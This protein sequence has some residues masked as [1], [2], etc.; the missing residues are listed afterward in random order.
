MKELGQ[1]EIIG[2]FIIAVAMI[3]EATYLTNF[4]QQSEPIVRVVRETEII[5]G[6]NSLEFAKQYLLK[7][8]LYSYYQASYDIASR[9]GYFNLE[10]NSYN[11]IPYL[12]IYSSDYTPDVQSSMKDSIS[13]IFVKYITSPDFNNVRVPTVF[14]V[15]LSNHGVLVINSDETVQVGTE[16]FYTAEELFSFS[17]PV[18]GKIFEL[19]NVADNVKNSIL[20]LQKISPTFT[21]FNNSLSLLQEAQNSNY[22]SQKLQIIITSENIAPDDTNYAARILVSIVDNSQ[23]IPSYDFSSNA[24]SERNIVFQFYLLEGPAT[25]PV[26]TNSCANIIY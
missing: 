20:D 6:I 11:C 7:S 19:Y 15:D 25:V 4:I 26:P 10:T 3:T 8:V 12:N 9:G 21:S 23:K 17:Q 22:E 1:V 24:F 13:S 2:L 5:R 16:D 14:T 18:D